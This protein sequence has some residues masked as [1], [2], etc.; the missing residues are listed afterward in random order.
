MSFSDYLCF[1]KLDS[2]E[3]FWLSVFQNI[4]RTGLSDVFLMISLE[5]HGEGRKTREIKSF[6]CHNIKGTFCQ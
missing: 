5:L 3:E 4:Y 6:S 2:F 1:D